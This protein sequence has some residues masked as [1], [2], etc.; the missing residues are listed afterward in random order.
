MA[1]EGV[2]LALVAADNN[3]LPAEPPKQPRDRAPDAAG[4]AR[5]H[6]DAL[7]ERVGCEHRRMARKLVVGQ[8]GLGG[9]ASGL[10]TVH[11]RPCPSSSS[12]DHTTMRPDSI[13]HSVRRSGSKL[14]C[15]R[16]PETGPMD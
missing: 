7:I 3:A 6:H 10:I 1:D 8:A 16:S 15:R 13:S 12:P 5:H 11:E 2:E 4:A 9:G 14:Q